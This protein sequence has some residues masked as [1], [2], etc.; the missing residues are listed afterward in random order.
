M[1]P[2]RPRRSLLLTAFIAGI[3][4]AGCNPVEHETKTQSAP[5]REEAGAKANA[6]SPETATKELPAAIRDLQARIQ[7]PDIPPPPEPP[8]EKTLLAEAE[9]LGKT[10][11]AALGKGDLEAAQKLVFSARD[12][13]EAVTPGHRAILEPNLSAQNDLVVRRLVEALRGKQVKAA[14]KPGELTMGAKSVFRKE[15]PVLS[16]STLE[17][18]ADGVPV[19]I[20]VDQMVYHADAWKLFRLSL[21]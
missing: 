7:P 21:P 19:V 3:S 14:W 11:V 8:D 10:F 5:A 9:D 13:E 4:A 2:H 6:A 16:G 20:R 12:Y 17:V 15:L 1:S 18:D